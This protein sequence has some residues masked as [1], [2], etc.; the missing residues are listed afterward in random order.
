[1]WFLKAHVNDFSFPFPLHGT[2]KGIIYAQNKRKTKKRA[3][4]LQKFKP[5]ETE[6]REHHPVIHKSIDLKL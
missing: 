3:A 5:L 4:P 6:R 1:M 2:F